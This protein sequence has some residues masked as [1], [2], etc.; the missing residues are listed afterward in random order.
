MAEIT[1]AEADL[2]A[3]I[4]RLG[5]DP[6]AM[7]RRTLA[8]IG[9]VE[10][11]LLEMTRETQ[12][13]REIA[14]E[15]TPTVKAISAKSGISRATFYNNEDL[16]AYARARAAEL[17]PNLDVEESLRAQLKSARDDIRLMQ[18]RDG[19]ILLLKFKVERLESEV[20]TLEED[21]ERER[22]AHI[23]ELRLMQM[24]HES[25]G[26]V[27]VIGKRPKDAPGA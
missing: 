12:R 11:A 23:D 18:E 20:K 26:T 5:L 6:S 8:E 4:E 21:L 7:S 19:M 14:A 22:R 24:R 25:A 27:K 17:F 3:T 2:P 16:G 10:D 1:H 9:K 13:A 15:N